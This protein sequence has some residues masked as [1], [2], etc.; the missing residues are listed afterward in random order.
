MTNS[1][2]LVRRGVGRVGVRDAQSGSHTAT[3][4]GRP[5]SLTS[6]TTGHSGA[7]PVMRSLSSTKTTCSTAGR[8]LA[9][10]VAGRSRPWSKRACG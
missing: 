10:C 7:Q 3:E 8:M 4:L 5:R 6:A 1:K 9:L 2:G